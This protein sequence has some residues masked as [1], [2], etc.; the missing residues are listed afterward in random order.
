MFSH[1]ENNNFLINLHKKK[2]N[3]LSSTQFA[4][5]M[6]NN[7]LKLSQYAATKEQSIL[8]ARAILNFAIQALKNEIMARHIEDQYFFRMG[9]RTT[10][11]YVT[12]T[13]DALYDLIVKKPD[14]SKLAYQEISLAAKE[15]LKAALTYITHKKPG[16]WKGY[17]QK[18]ME[19]CALPVDRNVFAIQPGDKGFQLLSDSSSFF[20]KPV[21]KKDPLDSALITKDDCL[22]VRIWLPNEKAGV[23]ISFEAQQYGRKGSLF[24]SPIREMHDGFQRTYFND[25]LSLANAPDVEDVLN[26]L[27]GQGYD[28]MFDYYKFYQKMLM[29]T[30]LATG[31]DEFIANV[32]LKMIADYTEPEPFEKVKTLIALDSELQGSPPDH[33]FRFTG[34]NAEKIWQRTL[35]YVYPEQSQIHQHILI[36]KKMDTDLLDEVIRLLKR[37]VNYNYEIEKKLEGIYQLQKNETRVEKLVS[38]LSEMS[39][40]ELKAPHLTQ[41]P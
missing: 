11:S 5:G 12:R 39:T 22:I 41:R 40:P 25:Y 20:D 34:M 32:L 21:E 18:V 28:A 38:I 24:L 4:L 15:E 26:F 2:E 31:M 27:P 23:R 19:F 10:T 36:T 17:Y 16:L 14:F 8:S 29:T 9:E 3:F 30:F 13:L 7:L 33:T 37:A 35:G 6:I 1:D